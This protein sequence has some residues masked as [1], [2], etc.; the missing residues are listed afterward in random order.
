MRRPPRRAANLL[1]V[2]AVAQLDCARRAGAQASAAARGR[3]AARA[4]AE[5]RSS[6][7]AHAG[8]PPRALFTD[9]ALVFSHS[10]LSAALT[11]A[12]TTSTIRRPAGIAIVCL[13]HTR[14]PGE[15]KG[16]APVRR[17]RVGAL[18]AARARAAHLHAAAGGDTHV[19]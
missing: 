10:L 18:R 5:G 2:G 1:H 8:G 3:A 17:R 11:D 9:A 13:L 4:A 19:D 7:L 12:E 14:Q 16:K 15:H 6:D